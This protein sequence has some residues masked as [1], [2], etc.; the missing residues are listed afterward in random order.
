[1]RLASIPIKEDKRTEEKYFGWRCAMHS[2]DLCRDCHSSIT[3]TWLLEK[4]E[5][6]W[7]WHWLVYVGICFFLTRLVSF[8]LYSFFSVENIIKIWKNKKKHF[9]LKFMT[10][11]TAKK[12]IEKKRDS[13]CKF[14][15]R[16]F[17]DFF[18]I[19]LLQ[20]FQQTLKQKKNLQGWEN[21][22]KNWNYW[23]RF[24]FWQV[25]FFAVNNNVTINLLDA[26]FALRNFETVTKISSTCSS[27]F[28]LFSTL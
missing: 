28:Y 15:L 23:K 8:T 12:K 1:M 6:I 7:P 18:F 25:H 16:I 24:W 20:I 3:I 9:K 4:I 5:S 17:R 14:H 27:Y 10:F 19:L 26:K 13:S 2:I 11:S 22:Q 21:E